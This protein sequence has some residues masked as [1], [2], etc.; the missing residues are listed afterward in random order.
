M[1]CGRGRAFNFL[2]N[3]VMFHFGEFAG[4]SVFSS[5]TSLNWHWQFNYVE[6]GKN[7][8]RSFI[9]AER[10]A[11]VPLISAALMRRWDGMDWSQSAYC[12]VKCVKTVWKWPEG[13]A[14]FFPPFL[15]FMNMWW[16]ADI[17]SWQDRRSPPG[18]TVAGWA[19][20]RKRGLCFSNV[21]LPF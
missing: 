21:F 5:P 17:W 15:W 10:M 8:A 19:A 3:A 2:R 13:T 14:G 6:Q 12:G 7:A 1:A 9:S 16:K 4:R 18:R 11:S 20:F